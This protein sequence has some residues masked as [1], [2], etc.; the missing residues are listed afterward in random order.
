MSHAGIRPLLA[1]TAAVL[2][3]G[4]IGLH[5]QADNPK[6]LVQWRVGLAS[7]AQPD[8]DFLRK[9]REL[10]YEVVINLAPPQSHG[11]FD[12]E[13]GIVGSKGL[14]YVNIP[15]DFGKPTAEDFRMFT[16][17]MKA[18]RDKQVF[19]HCQAN[20]RGTSFV[21]LYRVLHEGATQG[22]AGAKLGSVWVPDAVWKRFIEETLVANGRKP[23]LF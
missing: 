17:V 13:G 18:S 23:E 4:A 1:R 15:V 16:E 14:V 3:A 20:L 9:L 8:K 5:A 6:N 22:E 19:V 21:F 7:A 11:S 10:G 2:F 12:D